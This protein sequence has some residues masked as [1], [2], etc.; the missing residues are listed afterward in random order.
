MQNKT[1]TISPT[2]SPFFTGSAS[3]LTLL[4]P[5]LCS[6]GGMGNAVRPQHVISATPFPLL[7]HKVP[8]TADSPSRT[9]RTSSPWVTVLPELPQHGFFPWGSVV[10]KKTAPVWVLH[11]P[12]RQKTCSCTGCSPKA[13]ASK[14]LLKALFM[15]C[16]FLQG[17]S[18]CS[19]MGFSLS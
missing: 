8:P 13:L 4:S 12:H 5:L 7:Q 11:R 10:Q 17:M 14:L 3:L 19:S 6:A 16:V 15:G 9:S 1:K 2:H 18:T